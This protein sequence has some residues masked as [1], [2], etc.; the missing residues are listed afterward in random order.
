MQSYESSWGKHFQKT[1]QEQE[2]E[3][4][5][6][7]T[8]KAPLWEGPNEATDNENPRVSTWITGEFPNPVTTAYF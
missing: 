4:E 3:N 7:K 2:G 1:E 5:T 8:N 6:L